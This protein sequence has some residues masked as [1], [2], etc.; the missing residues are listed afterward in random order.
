MDWAEEARSLFGSVGDPWRRL[1]PDFEPKV[2]LPAD[3]T[4]EMSWV[5]AVTNQRIIDGHVSML[6]SA[7]EGARTFARTEDGA[8]ADRIAR[9]LR[10]RIGARRGA[11]GVTPG[12]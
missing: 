11:S 1:D 9:Y 5:L 10:G 2:N 8:E 12:A 3:T 4:G 7:W 6:R